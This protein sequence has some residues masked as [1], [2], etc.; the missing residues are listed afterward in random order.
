MREEIENLKD[1]QK[2]MP[3]IKKKISKSV[4]L[5][6]KTKTKSIITRTKQTGRNIQH[7]EKE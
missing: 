6:A 1:H 3:S 2:E 5:V 7:K 4:F